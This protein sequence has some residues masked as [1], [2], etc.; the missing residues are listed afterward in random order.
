MVTEQLA[1]WEHSGAMSRKKAIWTRCCS[2][3]TSSFYA[4]VDIANV[5]AI[6]PLLVLF[7]RKTQTCR[8]NAIV[9]QSRILD[10][11]GPCMRTCIVSPESKDFSYLSLAVICSCS[12]LHFFW[13]GGLH[14]ISV[15]APR[16]LKSEPSKINTTFKSNR[17]KYMCD[18]TFIEV[19]AIIAAWKLERG[20]AAFERHCRYESTKWVPCGSQSP[21]L[22]PA[23]SHQGDNDDIGTRLFILW[24]AAV[25]KTYNSCAHM[26]GRLSDR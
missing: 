23:D 21:H 20:A 19:R 16:S 5:W 14:M 15:F 9:R 26:G 13:K 7:C 18:S 10:R 4:A 25:C 24:P 8:Q 3:S 11:L 1:K 17:F 22:S 2:L 12:L 6:L